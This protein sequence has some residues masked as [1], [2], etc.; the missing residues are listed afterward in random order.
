MDETITIHLDELDESGM[1]VTNTNT[2]DISS[3]TTN[4]IDTTGYID[5]LFSMDDFSITL[6]EPVE[7]EDQ[8]PSV[9]KIEDMCNNYPALKQAYEKFKTIYAM[10]H[11]DWQGKQDDDKPPF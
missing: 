10:V 5:D 4:T 6:S 7:F 1:H 2:I 8:M 3:I 11:Q 9:A